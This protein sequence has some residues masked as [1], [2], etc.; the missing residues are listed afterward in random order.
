MVKKDKLDIYEID[1][2][3]KF[4]QKNYWKTITIDLEKVHE[5]RTNQENRYYHGVVLAILGDFFGYDVRIKEEI[6][7]LKDLLNAQFLT[8]KVPW[9]KDRRRKILVTKRSS[10]LNTK[11]FEEFMSEIRTWAKVKFGVHIPL[12]NEE[13]LLNNPANNGNYL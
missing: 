4:C 8:K 6:E 7:E 11:E 10:D 5:K 12:P 2:F 13:I 1:N 9:S 3:R